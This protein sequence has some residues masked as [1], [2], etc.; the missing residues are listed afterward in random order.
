MSV[1]RMIP[2]IFL[3]VV[4]SALAVLA[5]LYWWDNRQ[6]AAPTAIAL[7]PAAQPTVPIANPGQPATTPVETAEA[8]A[9]GPTTYRVKA[10][11]TLGSISVTFDVPVEDIMTVNGL[12]DPNVLQVDQE[13]IIPIGGIPTPTPPPTAETQLPTPIATAAVA[14]GDDALIEV[15]EVVSVGDLTGEAVSIANKGS[16]PIALQGWQLADEDGSVYT[17]GQ[18]ILFGDGAAILVHSSP[19]EDGPADLYWDLTTAV[20]QKGEVVRLLDAGGDVRAEYTI[21]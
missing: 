2:F 6:P 12:A 17:F 4:V 9:E 7:T 10:G 3:N 16:Q 8:P 21:P 15:V 19:G 11:D 1:R 5:V 13:L 14:Q 20:W 18:V